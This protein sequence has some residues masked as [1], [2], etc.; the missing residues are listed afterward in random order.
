MLRILAWPAFQNKAVQ[1]YNSLLYT[2]MR[3]QGVEVTEFSKES[4]LL[5]KYDIL[6]L[7]WPERL[8]LSTDY[9][10]ATI[11]VNA[12]L[13]LLRIVKIRGTKIIWTVH[14]LHSHEQ[15][16]PRLETFFWRRFTR[17]VDGF[18]SMSNDGTA[19]ALAQFPSLLSKPGFVIPMGHFRS[20][21]PNK[22]SRE[23]ARQHLGI[24]SEAKVVLFFGLLRSYKNVEHL[25]EVFSCLRNPNT[26]LLIAGKPETAE[27]EAGIRLAAANLQRVRLHLEF[28]PDEDVQ[29]FL[30]AADLMALPYKE[31]LNSASVLLSLSFNLPALVPDKGSLSELAREVGEGWIRTYSGDL[32]PPKLQSALEWATRGG[33]RGSPSLE[34][35]QWEEIASSTIKAYNQVLST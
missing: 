6:H 15:P 11:K 20:V 19:A 13:G 17:L 9:R 8:L 21:Y 26:L 10:S 5:H 12:L 16:Y 31:I 1:P 14:N 34:M 25:V 2:A 27:L 28:I 32:D 4:A 22:V 35:Y 33:N 30:S 7:H 24:G 29:H 23:G 18:I 3:Q